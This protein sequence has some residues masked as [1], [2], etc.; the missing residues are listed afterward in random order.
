MKTSD[1]PKFSIGDVVVLDVAK[2]RFM[3]I[4]S[5]RKQKVYFVIN[6]KDERPERYR[7]Y[8][9]DEKQARA[10]ANGDRR[11]EANYLFGFSAN[12]FIEMRAQKLDSRN[13]N[14]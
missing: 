9:V 2:K 7:G 3:H 6:D 13:K 5:S 14:V 1:L 8:T 11:L 12:D 10:I 4:G